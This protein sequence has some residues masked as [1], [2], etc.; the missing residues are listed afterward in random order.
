MFPHHHISLVRL[1]LLLIV[2]AGHIL[3]TAADLSVPQSINDFFADGGKVKLLLFYGRKKYVEVMY[4][5]LLAAK[6]GG[7]NSHHAIISQ[8]MIAPL[9]LDAGDLQYLDEI[10]DGEYIVKAE[11]E[12]AHKSASGFCG[13]I[14]KY[15]PEKNTLVIKIDHDIVYIHDHS[16]YYMLKYKLSH[17]NLFAVSANVINHSLL[18][19]VH[20][21][22]GVFYNERA[23]NSSYDALSEFYYDYLVDPPNKQLNGSAAAIVQHTILLENLRKGTALIKYNTFQ[24]WDFNG[25]GFQQKWSVNCFIYDP[26]DIKYDPSECKADGDEYY[27][28]Q[29]WPSKLNKHSVAIG[30]ALVAHYSF[31]QQTHDGKLHKSGLLEKYKEYA[32]H[33]YKNHTDDVRPPINYNNYIHVEP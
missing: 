4:P 16:F 23:Y 8:I 29:L 17:P 24:V 18:A 21:M 13:A 10:V 26:H 27:F 3:V 7:H 14:H 30:N 5:Q 12:T 28:S 9:T 25:H 32:Y 19:Y 2:C 15:V 20:A 1:L 33:K 22:T 6:R 11:I 31:H